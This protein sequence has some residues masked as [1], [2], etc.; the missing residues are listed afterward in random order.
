VVKKDK[1]Y[2]ILKYKDSTTK[3]EKRSF[4]GFSLTPGATITIKE[5]LKSGVIFVCNKNKTHAIGMRFEQF[6]KM[7]LEEV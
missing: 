4:M 6:N 7:E 1:Q 2:K 3:Q 5:I